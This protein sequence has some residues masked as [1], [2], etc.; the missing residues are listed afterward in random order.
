MPLLFSYGTLQQQRVQLATFGRC[1][2]GERDA[3]PRFAPAQVRIRD[4]QI[5]ASMNRTHFDNARFTGNEDNV[6]NGMALQVTD[7]ELAAADEY[8]RTADYARI[9]VVL[10]SGRHAWVYVDAR[11]RPQR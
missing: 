5:V 10:A 11:S 3:L 6:V 9:D 2:D 4:A 7:A 8:E 1:L